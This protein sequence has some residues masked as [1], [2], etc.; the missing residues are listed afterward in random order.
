MSGPAGTGGTLARSRTLRVL[1]VLW[2]AIL[3]FGFVAQ[4]TELFGARGSALALALMG[5]AAAGF[6]AVGSIGV[7]LVI[8]GIDEPKAGGGADSPER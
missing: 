2:L 5:L 7:W 8:R 6:I 1:V 3:V 4:A